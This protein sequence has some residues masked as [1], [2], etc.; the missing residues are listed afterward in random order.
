MRALKRTLLL[1]IILFLVVLVGCNQQNSDNIEGDDKPNDNNESIVDEDVSDE[2]GKNDS[3]E[4]NPIEDEETSGE[5]DEETFY[6]YDEILYYLGLIYKKEIKNTLFSTYSNINQYYG[7]LFFYGGTKNPV[8]VNL[9][10]SKL[11]KTRPGTIKKSINYIVIHDTANNT[12]TATAYNHMIYLSNNPGVSWH[13]T[14]DEKSIYQHIPDNEVAYHAGDGLKEAGSTYYNSTYN[15]YC[16]TGGNANSI[17]IETCVNSGSD[18]TTTLFKT[19][20]LV[21]ELLIKYNLRM[22]D[23]KKHYDFSGKICPKALIT[24]GNWEEFI[25]LVEIC[26]YYKTRLFDV[27]LEFE[28]IT[29]NIDVLGRVNKKVSVGDNVKYNVKATYQDKSIIFTYESVVA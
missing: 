21:A 19:A 9:I 25:K 7:Y 26:Y 20:E 13:Y 16:M 8:Y 27:L 11:K 3:I 18:Y 1:T 5:I 22:G 6:K 23:V 17:G 24:S 2:T 12:S 28:C 4:N 29:T 14:V 15:K 10:D